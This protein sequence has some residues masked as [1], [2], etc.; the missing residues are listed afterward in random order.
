M[1][2]KDITDSEILVLKVIWDSG[3]DDMTL[4]EVVEAVN[5]KYERNWKPQTVSTFLKK[6]VQKDFLEMYRIGRLFCYRPLVLE[7]DYKR[8]VFQRHLSFWN[9]D[10]LGAFACDLA[11]EGLFD[12]E[13]RKLLR[14]KIDELL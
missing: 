13:Q 6:L 1:Y 10:D 4:P 14:K 3:R 11:D 8:T 5:A 7:S 12:N 2:K 9:N